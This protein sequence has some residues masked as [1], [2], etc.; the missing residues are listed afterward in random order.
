MDT[1]TNWINNDLVETHYLALFVDAFS[2]P[3]DEDNNDNW[4]GGTGSML[5]IDPDG[6]L[7]PYI[8]YMESSLCHREPLR[9]G[10]IDE[11]IGQTECT[12]NCIECLNAITRRTQSTNECFYCP[13]AEGCSWCSAYNY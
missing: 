8:R 5:S 13:I 10:H 6:H 2:K 7:Y 4:C 1:C 9:I 3:K 12:H 11:G